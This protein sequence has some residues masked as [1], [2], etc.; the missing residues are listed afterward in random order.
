MRILPLT[1]L[2]FFYSCSTYVRSPGSRMLSPEAQG[3]FGS[4]SLEARVQSLKEYKMDFAGN[5]TKVPFNED[6]A[7]HTLSGLGEL[8]V[9]DPIDLF[10]ILT[11]GSP[12]LIG[13][14]L[15]FLGDRR[16]TAKQGNFSASAA[17]AF[18]S[19]STSWKENNGD[20]DWTGDEVK[21][22]KTEFSHADAGLYIGYRWLDGLLHYANAIYYTE[23]MSG[24][25]TNR[26]ETLK[27]ARF[28]YKNHGAI[29]ST[30]F[31][32]YYKALQLKL[33]YSYMSSDWTY[34]HSE[35]INTV[36]GAI[37]FNF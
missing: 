4:G 6:Q 33:D 26:D 16:T 9:V 14:K 36:N 20:L 15:Q 30:G 13:G 7:K 12:F 35:Y 34:N 11:I 29:Y 8:G 19:R 28:K 37:G 1:V 10:A 21:K 18:G 25:V 2:L 17:V 32:Y 3:K 31:V 27:D 23:E 5:S 22:G 24:K